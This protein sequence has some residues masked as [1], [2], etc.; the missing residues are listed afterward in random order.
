MS[1]TQ[2]RRT[3]EDKQNAERNHSLFTNKY[4]SHATKDG[5]FE[6]SQR[7]RALSWE[8]IILE[9]HDRSKSAP[10]LNSS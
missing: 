5:R 9:N 7:M 2:Q 4:T 3:H 1:T 8:Q 6:F 10:Q